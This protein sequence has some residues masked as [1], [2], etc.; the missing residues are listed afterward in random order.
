M[1]YFRRRPSPPIEANQYIADQPSPSGVKFKTLE[2][3]VRVA[4]V[5]TKQGQD[6]AV[7]PG[8]WIV[9]EQGGV[10]HYPIDNEEFQRLYEYTNET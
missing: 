10:R 5:T 8:E 4:Y 1:P 2:N 9:T 3:G 6:V 7:M